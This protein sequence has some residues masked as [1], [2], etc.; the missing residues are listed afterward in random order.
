MSKLAIHKKDTVVVLSGRDK[1]KQG[2]VLK[3]H[4]ATE[5]R[6]ATALVSKINFVTSH[7][8]PTQTDPGGIQK[9]EAP[10]PLSKLMLVCPKCKKG[11]RPKF[12]RLGSGEKTRVCRKCSEVIL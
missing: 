8:K 6:P 5:K 2:E 11:I 10:L 7:N 3:V 4:A 12:D 9:K 1:G